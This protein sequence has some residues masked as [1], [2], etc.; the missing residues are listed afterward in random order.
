MQ[1]HGGQGHGGDVLQEVVEGVV[2]GAGRLPGPGE[3][4]EVEKDVGVVG[5]QVEVELAAGAE[6][7]EV[8]GD[9]PPGQKA[10]VLRDD[11]LVARIG[12]L[13]PPVVEGREEGADGWHQAGVAFSKRPRFR[14]RCGTG[15]GMRARVRR[16]IS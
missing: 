14:R 8:P 10:P 1:T 12:Q 9:T 7:K 5:V 6:L 4:V 3:A 11:V 16:G 13:V 15:L 2:D